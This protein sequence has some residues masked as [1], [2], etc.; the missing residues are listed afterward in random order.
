MCEITFLLNYYFRDDPR[1]VTDAEDIKYAERL[2][3]NSLP[4]VCYLKFHASWF[5]FI[6]LKIS[7]LHEKAETFFSIPN[8]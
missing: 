8:L 3:S 7:Q 2:E 6:P 4:Q 5:L 1:L